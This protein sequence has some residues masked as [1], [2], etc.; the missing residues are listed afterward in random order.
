MTSVTVSLP[1]GLREWVQSRI[2]TGR[3]ASA[4]D[5]VRD[6]IS[7]D[8]SG[9]RDEDHRL[10]ELDASIARGVADSDAGR[11][12]DADAVFDELEAKYS[13]LAAA[14]GNR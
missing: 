14:P 6:L 1:D 2:A 3:Y 4:G 7:R 8:R 5:Y 10:V 12:F 11:V 13:D 9:A